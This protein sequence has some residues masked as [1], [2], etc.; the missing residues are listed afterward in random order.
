MM[1]SDGEHTH[2][3]RINEEILEVQVDRTLVIL[4]LMLPE[5]EGSSGD[6]GMKEVEGKQKFVIFSLMLPEEEDSCGDVGMKEVEG[7]KEVEGFK[8]VVVDQ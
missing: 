7:W 5:E 1:V 8:E 4:C 6:V 3:I 2:L